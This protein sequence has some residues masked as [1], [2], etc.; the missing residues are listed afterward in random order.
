MEIE[1]EPRRIVADSVLGGGQDETGW[2]KWSGR[3]GVLVRTLKL[4]WK[5]THEKPADSRPRGVVPVERMTREGVL[6]APDRTLWRLGHSSLLL[7][8]R[9]GLWLT[10][11]VFAR[12]ASPVWFA[13]P[14]RFHQPPI[15]IKELPPVKV[16]LIS[17]D[18]YDHLDK[19]AIRKLAK[20][21]ELFVVPAR[22]GEILVKWGVDRAKVRELEWWDETEIDGVRL[23]ATPT[24]HFSGRS[25]WNRNQTLFA[26][27]VIVDP[28]ANGG[29]D[30][31]LRVFYG[32]DSGYFPGFRKIGERYG[33]FDVTLL[34][35][36][37][38]NVRWPVVHMQP[39]ETVQAHRDLG[40][41]WLLPIHN[42][43]FDLAMHPWVEP[44]ERV[45]AL[46]A[47]HGI[48]VC[49]PRFG[50]PVRLSE[51]SRGECWWRGVDDAV[52]EVGRAAGRNPQKL[53]VGS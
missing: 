1:S 28:G 10:D 48:E 53:P 9:G 43:T 14:K 44:M 30:G 2:Q 49:T 4:F 24:Q 18:H 11:P 26:S 50:E 29:R 41:N 3:L 34:E 22:V 19:R 25:L 47:R 16:V 39:E 46:A 5:F 6:A 38:Y 45:Q 27:W 13:G 12:R 17:H 31:E 7:K 21:T 15:S 8:L 40:G 36:G 52:A 20:K 23:A 42:G 51:M 32:A 35:N 37:A 33:P